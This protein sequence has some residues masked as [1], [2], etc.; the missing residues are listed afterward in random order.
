MSQTFEARGKNS[1]PVTIQ[2]IVGMGKARTLGNWLLETAYKAQG[3][4]HTAM[5]LL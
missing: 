3:Q 5:A 4:S 1:L 2:V